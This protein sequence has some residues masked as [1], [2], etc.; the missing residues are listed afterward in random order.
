LPAGRFVRLGFGDG[1]DWPTANPISLNVA[2]GSGDWSKTGDGTPQFYLLGRHYPAFPTGA[3][4]T[5][6]QRRPTM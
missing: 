2:V 5:D 3:T 6:R 1:R 4:L